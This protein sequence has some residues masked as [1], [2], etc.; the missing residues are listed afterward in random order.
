MGCF[1]AVHFPLQENVLIKHVALWSPK[2]RL[3]GSESELHDKNLKKPK[4]EADVRVLKLELFLRRFLSV[5]A[6]SSAF[7]DKHHACD[8]LTNNL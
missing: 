6:G 5:S 4:K 2:D 7:F 3:E 8:L 1:V